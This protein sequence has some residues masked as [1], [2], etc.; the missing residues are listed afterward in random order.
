MGGSC[1][2]EDR[3]VFFIDALGRCRAEDGKGFV[4][5]FRRDHDEGRLVAVPEVILL[6]ILVFLDFSYRLCHPKK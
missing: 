4:A 6:N 1:V 2:E 5:V 3:V